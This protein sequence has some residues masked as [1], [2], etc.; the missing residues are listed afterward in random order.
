MAGIK[1]NKM[2]VYKVYR[3][4]GNGT[5]TYRTFFSREDAENFAK[6]FPSMEIEEKETEEF[7]NL[8]WI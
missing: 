6:V 1:E 8:R 2:K 3:K 5:V 7:N 4:Y